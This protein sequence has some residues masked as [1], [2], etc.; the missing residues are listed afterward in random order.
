MASICTVGEV[1]FCCQVGNVL[2]RCPS[3]V[4][5]RGDKHR[6]CRAQG[7]RNSGKFSLQCTV[8]DVL[9]IMSVRIRISMLRV[10]N[11]SSPISQTFN[12]K[13]KGKEIPEK[14]L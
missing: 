12:T 13:F 5:L 1:L 11:S 14:E 9:L 3:I 6:K 2:E 4:P 10:K 7:Q 8:T